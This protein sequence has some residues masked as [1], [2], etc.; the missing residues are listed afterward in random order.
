MYIALQKVE[1][2]LLI[3]IHLSIEGDGLASRGLDADLCGTVGIDGQMVRVG[4]F[5]VCGRKSDFLAPLFAFLRFVG[6]DKGVEVQS[7][8]AAI[9]RTVSFAYVGQVGEDGIAMYGQRI[10]VGQGTAP[11]AHGCHVIYVDAVAAGLECL[12]DGLFSA[13]LLCLFVRLCLYGSG[14]CQCAG[15]EGGV[16]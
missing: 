13:C 11:S 2:G 4:I 16:N 12:L 10:V 1:K 6:L 3:R 5:V 7:L 8:S 9:R 15:Y 14:R